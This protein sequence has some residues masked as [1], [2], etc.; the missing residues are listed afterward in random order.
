MIQGHSNRLS[1][2]KT[3]NGRRLETGDV[4]FLFHL[5][6]M[7]AW[8]SIRDHG[9]MPGQ[10]VTRGRGRPEIYLTAKWRDFGGP[11]QTLPEY[12]A[13]GSVCVIIDAEAALEQGQ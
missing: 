5:T 11:S 7:G 9:V 3:L 8:K 4:K 12:P 1:D 10:M 2:P 6:T 13:D